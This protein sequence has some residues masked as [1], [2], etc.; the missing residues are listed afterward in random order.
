MT[1]ILDL[2]TGGEEGDET[3]PGKNAAFSSVEAPSVDKLNRIIMMIEAHEKL[4]DASSQNEV[5]FKG[6]L[7]SLKES[8]DRARGNPS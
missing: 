4:I 1:H 7:Q 3:T 6:V 8:L 2:R 5:Q